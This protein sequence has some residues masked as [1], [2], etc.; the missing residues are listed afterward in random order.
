MKRFHIKHQAPSSFL[1]PLLGNLL[2]PLPPRQA[3]STSF[4]AP[5]PG[6]LRT[7][8]LGESFTYFLFT[9]FLVCFVSFVWFCLPLSKKT[10]KISL[11]WFLSLFK[12]TKKLVPALAA[13]VF[14][15]P[16]FAK[17]NST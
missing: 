3:L 15:L 14:G 10:K 4:L 6:R 12:S 13:A 8:S 1:V 5:L 2:Q 9:L 17:M 16:T 7:S 11:V